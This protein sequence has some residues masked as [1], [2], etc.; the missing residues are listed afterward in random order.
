MN[1]AQELP[2]SSG[3]HSFGEN[4]VGSDSPHSPRRKSFR[5]ELIVLLIASA[6]FLG[7]IIS[8]P[9]L[10]DDVDSVQASIARNMLTSGDW[11][12]PQLD[13]IKYM[14]KP[15]LK[16]WL[17]AL[18]FKVFGVHDYVARL[19]LALIDVLLCWLVFRFGA[20]AF[21]DSA[22]FYAGLIIS[23]CVGL[24]L[25]TRVL[26]SD[27]QLTF[28]ITLAMW[29]LLRALDKDEAHPRTWGL[30]YWVSIA[31]AILLKGLIGAV[32]PLGAAF[33]YLSISKQLLSKQTW[34]RLAIGWG[35]VLMLLIAAPWHVMA[36]IKNP[37][38]FR[39]DMQSRPGNYRGFFWFYFFN[40]H[41]L[42]FLNL[43]YPRDYNTVPRLWFWLLNLVWLFPASVYLP[44]LSRL[45][46]RSSE[47]ASRTRLLA[48]CWT[49]F[50]MLFFS[51]SS[52]QEYY[53]M[54]V[55]PA[56]ALLLGCAIASSVSR[57]KTLVKAGN[58]LL[59][60]ICAIALAAMLLVLVHVWNLPTPGDISGALSSKAESSYTLSLGHMGDLTLASFAY[61]RKPLVLACIAMLIGIAGLL[62]LKQ[63]GRMF[64]VAVMMVVFFQAARLALV[65]FDP[66]LSSR[67]LAEVL[68]QLPPGKLI[69]SDQYY[70]FSS[71]FFYAHT[72]TYLL[73]GRINNLEYGSYA[74]GAPHVFLDNTGLVRMWH[75]EPH[76]YLLV[77]HE[78]LPAIEQV[79][80]PQNFKIV[81]ESGG[82]FL[83]SN[84]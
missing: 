74:P 1:N 29:C 83:L 27:S 33:L 59:T 37:P 56:M 53:S 11:I 2:R 70:P 19:P 30:L 51:F 10:M 60:L 20:W 80:G 9:A 72:N 79:I 75:S 34:R 35:M 39:F 66:Y 69:T 65:T 68:L 31:I 45:T 54:P 23:T 63:N 76:C 36:T 43:R 13:G 46:Y 40:E 7:G 77:E 49:A 12:T 8:P 21:G 64:A 50:V 15:P 25:F 81:K 73:N 57:G 67:A 24:F 55:Y 14:E 6:I 17:I 58:V 84:G 44:A 61:L 18:S 48:L 4:E 3:M 52:T 38:Y 28:A 42:R 82:K 16:Y 5:Y 62:G 41:I 71:V 22:G 78:F 26:I 32:F 47:R